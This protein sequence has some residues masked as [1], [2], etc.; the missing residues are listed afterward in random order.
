M[1]RETEAVTY[2]RA[3]GTLGGLAP[4]GIY[5]DSLLTLAGITDATQTPDVWTGGVFRAAVVVRQRAPIPR[6]RV[7]DEPTRT[8]DTTQMLECYI[9]GLTAAAIEAI[10]NRLYLLTQGHYFTGAF[11]ATNQPGLPLMD[12]PG[13]TEVGVQMQRDDYLITSIRTAA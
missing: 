4:G 6:Y 3:D 13:L 7:H 9:Y 2:Y 5:A 12:A 1:S 11:A 8:V 10:A